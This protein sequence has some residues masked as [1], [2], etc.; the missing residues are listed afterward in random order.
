M[1]LLFV[2]YVNKFWLLVEYYFSG[3]EGEFLSSASA[4]CMNGSMRMKKA[5]CLV[6][7]SLTNVVEDFVLTVRPYITAQSINAVM[8]GCN[9]SL[10]GLKEQRP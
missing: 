8:L 6:I 4:Q 2:L 3:L 10:S 5:F 7:L 1:I 9:K